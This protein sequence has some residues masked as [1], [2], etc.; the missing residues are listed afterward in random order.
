M[1]K[2]IGG[3]INDNLDEIFTFQA[4]RRIKELYVLYSR[5]SLNVKFYIASMAMSFWYLMSFGVLNRVGNLHFSLLKIQ[6]ILVNI[7]WLA[8]YGP[9]SKQID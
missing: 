2:S 1:P 9:N 3:I 8:N 6:N 7:R 5:L 4:S